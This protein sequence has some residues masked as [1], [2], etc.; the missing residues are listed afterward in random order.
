MKK[1]QVALALLFFSG[2]A[3]AGVP[4]FEYSRDFDIGTLGST[5]YITTSTIENNMLLHSYT[6]DLTSASTV[7]FTLYN[8]RPELGSAIPPVP[9]VATFYDINIFDSNN[10][11]LYKGVVTD[12]WLYGSTLVAKVSG[13][14]PV[15]ED[16]YLRIAGGIMNASVPQL[17]YTLNMAAA[18]V[19]EPE[20]YALMLAG[21]GMLA[22]RIRAHAS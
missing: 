2:V 8:L 5:P 16:Y 19:P 13:E 14:L 4:T 18:P 12:R 1:K 17:S 10:Q 11:E 3:H 6:F 20:S 15:G 22:W 7:D 9:I 21:L